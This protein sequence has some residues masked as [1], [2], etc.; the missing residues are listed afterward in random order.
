M[1]SN[2]R[3]TENGAAKAINLRV[4]SPEF[5]TAYDFPDAYRTSNTL[6]RLMNYQDRWL[7]NI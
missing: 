5:Q 3:Q 7:Y 6:D 4:K 1:G 2:P